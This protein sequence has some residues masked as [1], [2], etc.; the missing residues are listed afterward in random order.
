MDVTIE[1]LNGPIGIAGFIEQS[2]GYSQ[3]GKEDYMCLLKK[4]LYRLKQAPRVWYKLPREYL[5]KQGLTTL[6]TEA[7]VAA[8]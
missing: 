8:K 3:Q 2:E 7:C 6:K 1:F 4:S 5:Q